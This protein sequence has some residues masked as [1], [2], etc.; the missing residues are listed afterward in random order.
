MK[1]YINYKIK[2]SGK[3]KFLTKLIPHLEDL[4]VK[5]SFN[6]KKA[7]IALGIRY[8]R[9]KVKIPKVLRVDG[10]YLWKNKNTFWKNNLTKNAIKQSDAV[11]WQSEFCKNMISEI[12]KVK[13]KKEFVVFN[14]AEPRDYNSEYVK[15]ICRYH[16]IMSARWKDRPWKRLK[17]CLAVARETRKRENVY[18]WVAGRYNKDLSERGIKFLGHLKEKKLCKYL[19][20]SDAMLNLS[21][22]D[23]CPNAVVEGLCAGLP[24]VCNNCCGTKELLEN[25]S[26]IVFVD[27]E[28][29]Y[30]YLKTDN[31]P[32]VNINV[33]VDA[34]LDVL[35]NFDKKVVWKLDIKTIAKQYKNVFEEVLNA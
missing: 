21:Y 33:V 35:Y 15:R 10:V 29:K 16:V 22:N 4:G 24:V 18:F 30:K 9:G 5:C 32:K 1:L 27:P 8:W 13:P 11:I 6:M 12:M 23:W 3:G 31:P 28:P 25:N 7:D 14:G 2:D 26:R 34:L 19:S 17:D 20:S